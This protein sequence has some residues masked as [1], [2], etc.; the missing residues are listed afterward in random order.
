[1]ETHD[2]HDSR[3]FEHSF[4]H[5]T[6]MCMVKYE[7]ELHSV[8]KYICSFKLITI[9]IDSTSVNSMTVHKNVHLISNG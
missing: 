7:M 6:R 1:M 8:N 2:K 4:Y 9:L 3:F 5:T